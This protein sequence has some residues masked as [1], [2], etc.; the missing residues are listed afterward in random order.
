MPSPAE[1]WFEKSSAGPGLIA[2][3]TLQTE[4]MSAKSP[5]CVAQLS[6]L[7]VGAYRGSTL[8]AAF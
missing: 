8:F 7:H 4:C 5:C 1:L 6:G 2:F 3:V